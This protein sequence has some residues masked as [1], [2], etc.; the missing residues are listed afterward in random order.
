MTATEDP[1]ERTLRTW[2]A[3]WELRLARETITREQF[4]AAKREILARLGIAEAPAAPAPLAWIPVPGPAPTSWIPVA[5]APGVA[6]QVE[7]VAEPVV[8]APAPGPAPPAAAKRRTALR[9]VLAVTGVVGLLLAGLVLFAALP[10]ENERGP[11]PTYAFEAPLGDAKGP[12][13]D[14]WYFSNDWY[15]AQKSAYEARAKVGEAYALFLDESDSIPAAARDGVFEP[16]FGIYFDWADATV[17]FARLEYILNETQT[18]AEV[19]VPFYHYSPRYEFAGWGYG[20]IAVGLDRLAGEMDRVV[21]STDASTALKM[22]FVPQSTSDALRDA[23]QRA[24]ERAGSLGNYLQ[25]GEN[26]D[27]YVYFVDRVLPTTWDLDRESAI[28]TAE[29]LDLFE[30]FDADA[31]GSLDLEEALR[32]YYWVED[33]PSD[34]AVVQAHPDLES[35]EVC[36]YRYWGISGYLAWLD[37]GADWGYHHLVATVYVGGDWDE[38]AFSVGYA[39]AREEKSYGNAEGVPAGIY[40]AIDHQAS[41]TFGFVNAGLEPAE[42]SLEPFAEKQPIECGREPVPAPG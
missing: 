3:P 11:P 16:G 24:A 5:P 28:A 7:T 31:S 21:A 10:T 38:A 4:E 29:A 2:L 8:R 30:S 13:M 37:R 6:A 35:L 15:E 33:Q 36:F 40:W 20:R 27:R 41:D 25:E 32:F 39:R 18:L 34:D 17:E 19:G 12:L 42:I 26:E 1:R 9:V 14:T 22:G 23:A